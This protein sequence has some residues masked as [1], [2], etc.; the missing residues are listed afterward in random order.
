VIFLP[1]RPLQGPEHLHPIHCTA[2]NS[3]PTTITEVRMVDG[4]RD[5]RAVCPPS[6]GRTSSALWNIGIGDYPRGT[7]GCERPSREPLPRLRPPALVLRKRRF[8]EDVSG[9]NSGR[10]TVH[11]RLGVVNKPSIAKLRQ[12]SSSARPRRAFIVGEVPGSSTTG[13]KEFQDHP[14]PL[15]MGRALLPGFEAIL[16]GALLSSPTCPTSRPGR[17]VRPER[18]MFHICTRQDLV[19]KEDRYLRT[20]TSASESQKRLRI[21]PDQVRGPRRPVRERFCRNRGKTMSFPN[22]WQHPRFASGV[23]KTGRF[24][25]TRWVLGPCR[26]RGW[27]VSARPFGERGFLPFASCLAGGILLAAGGFFS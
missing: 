14:V 13:D 19:E 18:R 5:A 2:S 20:T 10:F 16:S 8:T 26:S 1:T 23:R 17:R 15:R 4:R 6:K 27:V 9:K 7:L 12:S 3:F 24:L 25:L 11:A 21:L 22:S